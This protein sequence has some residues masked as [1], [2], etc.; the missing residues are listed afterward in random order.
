MIIELRPSMMMPCH[1]ATTRYADA[2]ISLSML[3][4][5]PLMAPDDIYLALRT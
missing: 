3:A 5:K 1:A 4:M 2:S